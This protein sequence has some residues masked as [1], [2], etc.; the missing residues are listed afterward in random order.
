M[1]RC[2]DGGRCACR[3]AANDDEVELGCR[4]HKRGRS[5]LPDADAQAKEKTLYYLKAKSQRLE[6]I[7]HLL[8]S[9]GAAHGGRGVV[10]SDAAAVDQPSK[11]RET[12]VDPISLKIVGHDGIPRNAGSF[13][14]ELLRLCR[15]EMMEKEIAGHDIKRFILKRERQRVSTHCGE[16]VCRGLH[17]S[18]CAIENRACY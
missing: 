17:V 10:A 1:P 11:L 16:G 6:Q 9:I 14:K 2:G 8:F 7:V 5:S 3:A 12:P 13:A 15:I 18:V 4:A